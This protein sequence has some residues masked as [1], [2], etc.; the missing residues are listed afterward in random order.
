MTSDSIVKFSHVSF[1]Y[2]GEEMPTLTDLNLD[3]EKGKFV[4]IT[5]P[6]GS[7]KSTLC[8]LATGIIPNLKPGKLEGEAYINGKDLRHT[9]IADFARFVGRV[10][11][12]P[13]GQFCCMTVRDEVAFGPENLMVETEAIRQRVKDVLGI[14]GLEGYEDRLVLNLSGGEK[15]RLAIACS[16][17]MDP[18]II[19][20]DEPTS[21]LDPEGADAV[22]SMCGRLKN[23]GKTVILVSKFM[24]D[25]VE[26]AD[27]LIVLNRDGR[28]F[29]DGSP[30]DVLAMH[31][32]TLV[33]EL[34]VWIPQVSQ[35]E[36]EL[37]RLGRSAESMP[38]TLEEAYAS[39]KNLRFQGTYV[40]RDETQ[41]ERDVIRA[42]ELGFTYPNGVKAL[43]DVSF[44]VKRG[45]LA[46]I[47]GHNGAGKSTLAR[48]I[49]G[50]AKPTSGSLE[51]LG[52]DTRKIRTEVSRKIA[53]VFQYPEHQFLRNTAYEEVAYSL[54]VHNHPPDDI[55]RKVKQTLQMLDLADVRDKHPFSLSMGQKRRLSVA[56]MLVTNP[57]IMILD[58]PTYGQ[59]LA[60]TRSL[61]RLA[62]D[63]HEAGMTLIFITHDMRLAQEISER[64]IVMSKGKVIYNGLSDYLFCDEDLLKR[65]GLKETPICKLSRMLG[66]KA[67]AP[68]GIR[69]IEDFIR[70]TYRG[71]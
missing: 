13:E 8:D 42:E 46:A 23:L 45:E 49:V 56:T 55:D 52:K 35:V 25:F 27:K 24:D 20:T 50:L 10:F 16:L 28:V 61:V 3:I 7:G 5:G 44:E 6:S 58:E 59:D 63:L 66:Q 41:A 26:F 36:L 43:E 31:G 34:G 19:I 69:T 12:D 70:Y 14:V 29:A 4:L 64:A 54:R 53:Y 57:E 33:N 48:L 38:L 21:N 40:C 65:A 17:A 62:R 47:L 39:Y 15:Q 60:M 2:E 67:G 37:R 1:T 71:Q 22:V 11:Q 18:E 32:H 9:G 51:V 68:S 30:R